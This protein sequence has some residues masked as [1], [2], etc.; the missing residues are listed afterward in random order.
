VYE[1]FRKGSGGILGK[2]PWWGSSYG[3]AGY[4]T[5]YVIGVW[6]D[7]MTPRYERDQSHRIVFGSFWNLVLSLWLFYRRIMIINSIIAR[8]KS[9][10]YDKWERKD[11]YRYEY[12]ERSS[13]RTDLCT[14]W[15]HWLLWRVPYTWIKAC[16]TWI[17]DQK[18]K[19]EGPLDIQLPI[20]RLLD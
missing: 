8:K 4:G 15:L 1:C 3:R 11:V 14:M 7:A 18:P 13:R 20:R 9:H 16:C 17:K 12:R 5:W 6:I 19:D 2:W 10:F